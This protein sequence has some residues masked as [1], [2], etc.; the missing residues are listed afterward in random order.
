MVSPSTNKRIPYFNQSDVEI[1]VNDLRMAKQGEK[2]PGG[3]RLTK[4][5]QEAQ[6]KR[7][8]EKA[9]LKKDKELKATEG[10]EAKKREAL[11]RKEEAD[12]KALAAAQA[13]VSKLQEE[14]GYLGSAGLDI[15]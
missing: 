3:K 10:K 1:Q 4:A 7:E 9:E 15:A 8:L 5:E 13:L 11:K 6:K 12:D 2:A 14:G